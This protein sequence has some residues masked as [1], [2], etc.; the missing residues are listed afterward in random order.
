M[1]RLPK[2]WVVKNPTQIVKDYLAKTYNVPDVLRWNHNFIGFDGT[3]AYNGVHGTTC[4]EYLVNDPAILTLDEFI[5]LS[6][7]VD[8]FV[9]PEKWCVKCT[10]ESY[11]V[12]DKWFFQKT[13][14][15]RLDAN[16]CSYWHYPE[17]SDG[18]STSSEIWYGYKEITFEQFQKYVLKLKDVEKKIMGYKLKDNC[19]QYFDAV[20]TIAGEFGNR[21]Q[22][23]IEGYPVV[24]KRLEEAGVLDLWF[25]PIYEQ[26]YPDIIINGRKGEFFNDYVK[27]GCAEIG[28]ELFI[29]INK[30]ILA[31]FDC[32]ISNKEIESVTIG[33]GTF[34]KEQ[35]KQIAGYYLNKK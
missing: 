27:F 15:H 11:S 33:A 18:N 21:E 8:E 16:K 2:Y 34:T 7:E 25:E 30:L 31:R 3:K 32:G 29:Q 35:I 19:L 17:N 1:N 4:L 13:G 5:E 22:I 10:K 14:K 23:T 6:K 26:E 28:K 24:I 12:L 9:L 20:D